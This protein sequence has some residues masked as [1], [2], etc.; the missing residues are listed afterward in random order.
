MI[1]REYVVSPFVYG[2]KIELIRRLFRKEKEYGNRIS[3]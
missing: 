3:D 1:H 2:K